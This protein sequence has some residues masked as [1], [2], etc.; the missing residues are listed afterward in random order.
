VNIDEDLK[1]LFADEGDRLA[2]PVR[3]DAERVIVAGARRVRRNRRVA[4]GAV[5][6]AAAVFVLVGNQGIVS[7]QRAARSSDAPAV[8]ATDPPVLGPTG[9]G[10]LRLGQSLVDAM[11]TEMLGGLVAVAAGCARYR[12]KV[13]GPVEGNYVLL[14]SDEKVQSFV[15][16]SVRTPE[17][18]G[19]GA[20]VPQV[21]AAYPALDETDVDASG[22]ATVPVPGVPRA[23]YGFSFDGEDNTVG[24]VVLEREEH[25]CV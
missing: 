21:R 16:D 4:A 12:L 14:S 7:P 2:V 5:V 22:R 10:G 13:D 1:R 3:L 23:I 8:V 6:T 11:A 15:S 24:Q 25:S 9:I 17:G 20:T 18:V 19:P